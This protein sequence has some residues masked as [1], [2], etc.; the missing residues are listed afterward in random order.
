METHRYDDFDAFVDGIRHANVRCLLISM[1]RRQWW[2]SHGD[3]GLLQLQI[4]HDA[5]G[6]ICEGEARPDGV[7]IYFPLTNHAAHHA[8][9]VQLDAQSVALFGPRGEFCLGIRRPHDWCSLFIPSM[10]IKEIVGE[11]ES[12]T[13]L[14]STCRAV[15][16]DPLVHR[17]F[18]SLVTSIAEANFHLAG[19]EWT[20]KM[21]AAAERD[22]M[23]TATRMP[24]GAEKPTRHNSGRPRRSRQEIVRAAHDYLDNRDE[25]Q[26]S[27]SDLAIACGVSERTLRTA[28]R[29]YFGIGPKAYRNLR[30]LHLVRRELIKA[31]AVCSTVSDILTQYGVWEHGRFAQSYQKQFGELP[32]QTLRKGRIAK[33]T[34]PALACEE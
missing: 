8:N 28:F 14:Q 31:T 2:I 23:A 29:E 11:E 6:I 34:T 15:R 22:L 19:R 16:I 1:Q 26:V 27:V 13:L 5:A 4:G 7:V 30:V 3:F 10:A 24:G 17:R 12:V 33:D 25:P 32:S 9:G 20:P 21:K 18:R